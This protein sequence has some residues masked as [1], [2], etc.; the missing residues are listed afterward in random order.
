MIMTVE[1]VVLFRQRLTGRN[2]CEKKSRTFFFTEYHV[3]GRAR[4]RKASLYVKFFPSFFQKMD[5]R[6]NK[7]KKK[8]KKTRETLCS[9]L[10]ICSFYTESAFFG[11]IAGYAIS[12][13]RRWSFSCYKS[14]DFFFFL[15]I[16]ERTTLITHGVK[17]SHSFSYLKM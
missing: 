12:F 11:R 2:F 14:F 4:S 8:K 9:T 6:M 15:K 3:S 7:K 1:R 17:K 16:P 10:S 5:I 13:V